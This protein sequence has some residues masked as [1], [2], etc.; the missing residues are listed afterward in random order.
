MIRKQ[1]EFYIGSTRLEYHKKH[2]GI[3]KSMLNDFRAS[4]QSADSPVPENN[5]N[6]SIFL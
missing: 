3:E 4:S 5:E 6:D 2:K 1:F